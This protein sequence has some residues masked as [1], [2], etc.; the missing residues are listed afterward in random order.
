MA[1]LHDSIRRAFASAPIDPAERR[2]REIH[3]EWDR[4]LALAYGPADRA[5]I[6]AIFSRAL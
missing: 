4:Q 6:N 1:R 2:A 3:R 5:E